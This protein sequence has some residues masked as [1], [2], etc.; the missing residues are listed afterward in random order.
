MC[1]FRM[2][3][4][5][6]KKH[7]SQAKVIGTVV[8]IAGALVVTF[9][10]G[11]PLINDAIKNIEMGASGIFLLGKSDWIIGAFLLA[12]GSFCLSLLFI[13]QVN[14]LYISMYTCKTLNYS[15]DFH[16]KRTTS[17]CGRCGFNYGSRHK[18]YLILRSKL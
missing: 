5:N 3:V 9:Y 10:K 16:V 2:E 14:K 17:K 1:I 8:S 12:A 18:K 6:M 13:V 11:I 15:C 4:L 7:S